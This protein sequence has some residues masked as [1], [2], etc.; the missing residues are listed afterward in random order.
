[1]YDSNYEEIMEKADR[2]LSSLQTVLA[3]NE[4]NNKKRF[5]EEYEVVVIPIA[6]TI[7]LL[8]KKGKIHDSVETNQY[9]QVVPIQYAE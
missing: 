6:P 5:E 7:Q 3:N 9:Q 8:N 1:M 2:Q 4:R